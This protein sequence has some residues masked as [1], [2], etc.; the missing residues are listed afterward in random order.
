MSGKTES[1]YWELVRFYLIDGGPVESEALGLYCSKERANMERAIY[2]DTGIHEVQ[3]EETVSIKVR[4]LREVIEEV[5]LLDM[6]E[7]EMLGA[8]YG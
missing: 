8:I 5:E 1:V 6:D 3:D 2:M 4:K 7:I